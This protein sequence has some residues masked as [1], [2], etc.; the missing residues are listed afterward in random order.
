MF[1]LSELVGFCSFQTKKVNVHSLLQVVAVTHPVFVV[2]Q[3]QVSNLL[4]REF[5]LSYYFQQLELFSIVEGF[6]D[7]GLGHVQDFNVLKTCHLDESR[8]V[9]EQFEVSEHGFCF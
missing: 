6:F 5:C 7:L 3:N 9:I 2:L 8:V 4:S 1:P